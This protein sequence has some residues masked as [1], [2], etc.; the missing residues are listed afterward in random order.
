MFW[1]MNIRNNSKW[2]SQEE[3]LRCLRFSVIVIVNIL[4][5]DIKKWEKEV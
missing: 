4:Y 1:S 5:G 2:E 3:N